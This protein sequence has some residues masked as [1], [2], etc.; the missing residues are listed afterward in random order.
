MTINTKKLMKNAYRITRD[1]HVTAL[2][3][4]VPG[5]HL[6]VKY[7]DLIKEI[8]QKYGNGTVHITTRQG[9]E[10]PGLPMAKMDEINRLI[11]PILRGLQQD[12]D[13]ALTSTHA[14][15]PAAGT[16]NVSACIGNRVC[17]YACYDTTALACKIERTIY[18]ADFH[19]KIAASGCP[20]DCIKG[21]MQ[22]IGVLGMVEPLYDPER[23]IS[24]GACV[25][26]CS[27]RATGA[28]TMV[29]YKV[30]RDHRRCLGCGECVLTCPNGAWTRGHTYY[31]L[32]I[33]GR[34][35]KVNPRVARPF[36][37]WTTEEAVLQIIANMYRYIDQYIDR[38]LPKEHVGYIV[39]RTGYQVFR[40][41]VLQDVPLGDKARVATHMD[42][43]GYHYDRSHALFK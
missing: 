24:C 35:G 32:V 26:N 3:I 22:D 33:M 8:A 23:C 30:H 39:D 12:T 19:V 7:L 16:R 14:G 28:L 36:I 5:G 25:D 37:Q 38:S 4:R 42:F 11:E 17:P 41:Q 1:R 21:H 9:F 13:V 20:N 15:Y 40:E 10:I 2:R 34:T 18:P 29:N 27:L 43:G 6:N 31:R